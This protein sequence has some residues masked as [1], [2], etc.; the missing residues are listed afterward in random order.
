MIDWGKP[1]RVI[2]I[3]Q[4]IAKIRIH[5]IQIGSLNLHLLFAWYLIIYWPN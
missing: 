2:E 3:G 5:Q 1:G 4:M